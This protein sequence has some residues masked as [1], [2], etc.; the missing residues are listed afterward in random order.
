M[1]GLNGDN[2]KLVVIL[3]LV[4]IAAMG[5]D[6]RPG[7]RRGRAPGAGS[8]PGL[9]GSARERWDPLGIKPKVAAAIASGDPQRMRE[10]AALLRPEGYTEEAAA[11]ESAA[12]AVE[13]ARRQPP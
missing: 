2:A 4:A 1:L 9:P 6:K 3:A 12:E 7:R 11:L 13:R 10:L 8:T 5:Q